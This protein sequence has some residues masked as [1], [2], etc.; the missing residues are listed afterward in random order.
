MRHSVQKRDLVLFFS[1]LHE[2]SQRS[3]IFPKGAFACRALG[4]RSRSAFG[5]CINGHAAPVSKD[6]GRFVT[7]GNTN[8]LARFAPWSTPGPQTAPYMHGNLSTTEEVIE[9]TIARPATKNDLGGNVDAEV[10]R[11]LTDGESGRR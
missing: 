1:A 7:S 10:V 9:F 4:N 6:R 8:E 11:G 5:L 2:L 3:R